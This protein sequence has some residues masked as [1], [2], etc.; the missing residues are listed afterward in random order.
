MANSTRLY[1]I[2]AGASTARESVCSSVR[3]PRR[4]AETERSEIRWRDVSRYPRLLQR[5]QRFVNAFRGHRERAEMHAD[6]FARL[7]IEM[8]LHG[9]GRIHVNGPHEPARLVCADREKGQVD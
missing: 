1:T 8:R 2:H 5:S 3:Q 4:L 7:E 9:L 6:A